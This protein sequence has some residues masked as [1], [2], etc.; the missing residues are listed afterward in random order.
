MLTSITK[1]KKFGISAV[2]GVTLHCCLHWFLVWTVNETRPN[3]PLTMNRP[4]IQSVFMLIIRATRDYI[5]CVAATYW[6][7]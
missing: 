6:R 3:L 4:I 7:L 2:R 5:W 1:R